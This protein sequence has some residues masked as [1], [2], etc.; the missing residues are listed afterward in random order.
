M[1]VVDL[2][3]KYSKLSWAEIPESTQQVARQCLMDW[4]ACTLAG[5]KEPLSRILQDEYRLQSGLCSV[6]GT[7]LKIP[8]QVAALV[9]GCEGHAL[10]FDDTSTV[11]GGHPSAPVIPAVLAEAEERECSGEDVL[12]AIV[13]GIEIESRLGILIGGEHYASGWHVTST[14]GVFGAAAGVAHLLKLDSEA[15]GHAMGLA[16]SQSSGLK[17]NFGTMT[18]PF[19]A[20]HAAE[21]GLLS[22]RLSAR[23]FTSNPD[24]FS[25][26]QGLSS[27]A[28]TG[29]LSED[30]YAY[31]A[32][33]WLTEHVLFKYHA[34]CYL[35]HASIECLLQLG[36][37]TDSATC[38]SITVTVNPS[39]LDVCGI[40]NPTSGLETKFSLRATSALTVLGYDTTNPETYADNLFDN[41]QV[42]QMISRVSVTTDESLKTTQSRVQVNAPDGN[43]VE[44]FYDTG[45]P[46]SDLDD[47]QKKLESKFQNLTAIV[48]TQNELIDRVRLFEKLDNVRHWLD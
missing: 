1:N 18:K 37:A 36:N 24:S 2:W 35:T 21:R 39:L 22:A 8:A 28:S 23:G 41:S 11:M 20:G 4:L 48:G 31:Y 30:R 44:A 45:I 34:A 26:N 13:V 38:E 27:A 42:N 19:H 16:A 5:S 12:T 15:F 33:Q 29:V 25:A 47:Q 10:D 6:V 7:E 3:G 32:D 9:N 40:E 14:M 43:S 46:A 17:S